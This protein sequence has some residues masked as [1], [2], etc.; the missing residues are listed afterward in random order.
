MFTFFTKR[1]KIHVDC[2]TYF[3]GLPD[4]FP[5]KY[6]SDCMP[7]WFKSIPPTLKAP[8]GPTVGTMRSCP[9]VNELFNT[10]L[11]IEAWSDMYIDWSNPKEGIYVQPEEIAVPHPNW[12]WN[13]NPAFEN[14][15]HLKLITPWKF[16]EKTGVNFMFTGTFW[17]DLANKFVVPNGVVEYKYQHTTSINIM[18]PKSGF[19]KTLTISAG[20]PIAQIVPLSEKDVVI[21]MHEISRDEY[22]NDFNSYVFSFN[23]QYYKRKKFLEK[24]C[25]M[26][27][28]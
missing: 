8:S 3:K 23:A 25:P 2:F 19:P 9:G 21:H 15:Q 7:S 12:Q 28:E 14:Y 24:N 26:R 17:S 18:I 5:I 4:L 6:A 11:I 10:G 27:Q 13:F 1:N 16:K 20:E 22:N